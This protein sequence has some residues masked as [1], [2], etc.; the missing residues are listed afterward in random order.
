MASSMTVIKFLE[1]L[2]TYALL[3]A[4]LEVTIGHHNPTDEI[5]KQQAQ[6]LFEAFAEKLHSTGNIDSMIVSFTN[7]TLQ[8]KVTAK[9]QTQTWQF[10]ID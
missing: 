10:K 8:A 2:K 5:T 6:A 1:Q 9:N 4:E 3:S 7:H